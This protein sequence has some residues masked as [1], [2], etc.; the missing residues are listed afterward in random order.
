MSSPGF[1]TK[2][3]GVTFS[4]FDGTNRQDLIEEMEEAMDGEADAPILTLVRERGNPYDSN[5]VA[6][7]DPQG[8]Q[9]GY[10][11]KEVAASIATDIDQGTSYRAILRAITGGGVGEAFGV[12]VWIE[13]MHSNAAHI[14]CQ[15]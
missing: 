5:A 11:S 1:Y 2:I 7:M 13:P 14:R 10:L 12:N 8:R 4:N 6:V 3:V 15:S 9:L